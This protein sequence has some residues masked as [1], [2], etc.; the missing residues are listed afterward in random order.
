MKNQ[1]E[2]FT[3]PFN[4]AYLVTG[5]GEREL[6]EKLAREE[7]RQLNDQKQQTIKETEK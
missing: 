2:L 6:S 5:D 7:A 3:L 4:L 1:S